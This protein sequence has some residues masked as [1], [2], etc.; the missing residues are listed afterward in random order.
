MVAP[1]L[2]KN[3]TIGKRGTKMQRGT[4]TQKR[5]I[6]MALVLVFAFAA[7]LTGC[8]DKAG[9]SETTTAGTT[10]GGTTAGETTA[11]ETKADN[12]E[13]K[14]GFIYVGPVND[15]GWTQSHD[16]GRKYLEEQLG[17]TTFYK[18]IVPE[19]A[20]SKKSIM[21]LVDQG[22]KVIFTTS[23]GY[24]DPTAEVA[25][26]NPDVKFLHCSGY[27][28]ADNMGNYFGRMY[29]SRYLS[30]IIAG[31]KTKANI[32]GYVAAMPIPEVFNGINAFTL[33]VQSVNP[34]AKVIVRWSNTWIDVT[35]EKEAA[36]A[37]LSESCDVLTLHNDST[38]VQIA[39]QEKG[40]FVIG[41]DLDIPDAAPKAYMTAPIWN[42]GPYYVDQVQ[43]A[44]D[45]TWKSE[46]YAGGLSD[47]MVDLAPLTALAPEGAQAKIDEVEKKI[48]DGSFKVFTGPIKDQSG[49][50]R[51]K[52]G[53]VLS[54]E[55]I[56]GEMDWFVQGVEGTVTVE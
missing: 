14:V 48:L 43:K 3:K 34:D 53:E 16:N 15:G 24:M 40:A 22:C 21:E 28:T 38:A 1:T 26:E 45:G 2:Y 5:I 17:V 25:K 10:A 19:G 33:G 39:A 55:Y 29:E 8:G 52:A 51:V 12:K 49:A 13:F 56:A 36:E 20:E 6:S 42:W 18:E 31:M 27:L 9:S 44:I 54:E 11:A 50:E 47:G 41:Y 4:K 7:L 46:A 23:F 35:K 32:I 37:L 30:G